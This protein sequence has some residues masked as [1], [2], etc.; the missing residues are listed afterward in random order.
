MKRMLIFSVCLLFSQM[1]KAQ[2]ESFVG[3]WH[4]VDF[5]INMKSLN[6]DGT[7]DSTW[8]DHHSDKQQLE[9][10][11]SVWE[12]DFHQNG[13]VIQV[14][15]MR[16]GEIESW[17]GTYELDKNT[18]QLNLVVEGRT[19]SLLYSFEFKDG[20]LFLTRSNPKGTMRILT[21]FNKD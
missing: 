16:T 11:G 21:Q 15:N 5:S 3:E 17:G 1:A 6:D 13:E 9:E 10:D 18:L 7:V 12:L 8:V 14:S 19:R 4:V 2:L 20:V